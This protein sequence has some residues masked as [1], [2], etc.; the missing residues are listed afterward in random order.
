M[1]FLK[2]F[3]EFAVKGNALDMAVGV[4][5]G[6]SDWAGPIMRDDGPDR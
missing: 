3:R 2:E 4:I 1:S 6:Y 5:L